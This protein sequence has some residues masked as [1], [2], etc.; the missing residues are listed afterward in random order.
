MRVRSFPAPVVARW[1][2]IPLAVGAISTSAILIRLT[3]APPLVTAANRMVLA[4][5]ILLSFALVNQ[6]GDL[7]RGLREFPGPLVVSGVLLGVH[8]ALWTN[9][10]FFTSVASAVFLID[11]HPAFVA[12][13]ARVALGERTPAQVWL[14]ILVTALGGLIITGGDFPGGGRALI[15]D[16][17]AL[18]GAV[19][20]AGYLVIGRAVRPQ[21]GLAAY[22]GIIYT[23][24]SAVI[25]GLA[26]GSGQSLLSQAERDWPVWLALVLIPTLG[27]HTVFNWS[28]RY[29]PASVVGVSI[30][31]E[32]VGTTL[33]AW[34]ILSEPPA[35]TA[36]IGGLV[37]LIGLYLALRAAPP[38]PSRRREAKA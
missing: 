9:A 11:S 14:G 31:G 34:L 28:L 15:G 24:A 4:S 8:F 6:R 16:A 32:P 10:L 20:F 18:A 19:A 30:L 27:G 13:A 3:T 37:L 23:L 22:T 2:A 26:L 36:A 21:L 5:V 33:L 7:A 25:G 1:G 12:L 38:S 35:A 17:M 29:V